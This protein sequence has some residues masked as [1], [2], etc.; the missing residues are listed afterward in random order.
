MSSETARKRTRSADDLLGGTPQLKYFVNQK[1]LNM[2][3]EEKMNKIYGKINIALIHT[4]SI[5]I[6]LIPEKT[7]QMLFKGAQPQVEQTVPTE[8]ELTLNHIKEIN[9]T[10]NGLMNCYGKDKLPVWVSEATNRLCRYCYK[11][12]KVHVDCQNCN[13]DMCEFCGLSCFDCREP[14]CNSCVF[15]L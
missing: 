1:L 5:K 10:G 13:I 15:L 7:V 14:I 2:K 9:L 12:S 8:K 11:S 3:D 6:H 4:M